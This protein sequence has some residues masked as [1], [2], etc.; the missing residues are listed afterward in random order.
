MDTQVLQ[1]FLVEKGG[2]VSGPAVGPGERKSDRVS[3]RFA[4]RRS[5]A[6]VE[7]AAYDKGGL[8]RHQDAD[9]FFRSSPKLHGKQPGSAA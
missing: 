6:T 9:F 3:S 2:I 5:K 1:N 7:M 4:S 8:K